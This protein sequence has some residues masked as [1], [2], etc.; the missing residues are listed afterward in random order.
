M[1]KISKKN[2]VTSSISLTIFV[3]IIKFFGLIKHIVIA[4]NIG[5]NLDTDSFYVATG[6]TPP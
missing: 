1:K 4:N 2:I 3:I 6:I 5:A